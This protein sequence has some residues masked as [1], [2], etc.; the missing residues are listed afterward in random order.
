MSA[1][2]PARDDGPNRT[3]AY[4]LALRAPAMPVAALARRAHHSHQSPVPP[5]GDRRLPSLTLPAGL[6][7]VTIV[8][9]LVIQLR[10]ARSEFLRGLEGLSPEEAVRRVLPFNAISWMV[11][12]LASQEHRY[13]VRLA[14]D[15][16]VVAGLHDLVG[17]G[18]PATTPPLDEMLA[19]WRTVTDGADAYLDTLTTPTLT[20]FL[21][22]NGRP[23]GETVGTLLLR[24]IYHYWF[25]AGEI[26]GARQ[27]LGH[28]DLPEFVGDMTHAAYR[29]ETDA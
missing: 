10:F 7:A 9:P 16:D 20:T 22:R 13:W 29:P 3:H 6:E 24:N 19:T 5:P 21:Q 23:V 4:Q 15:R 12:H 28:T 18:R 1:I 2:R 27:A 14:Q 8:Q 25:H 26:A 17:T 11:G